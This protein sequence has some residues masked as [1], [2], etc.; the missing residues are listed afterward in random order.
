[1][2]NKE[3]HIHVGQKL[4]FQPGY[5]PSALQQAQ[6]AGVNPTVNSLSQLYAPITREN[7]E[8]KLI[9]KPHVGEGD[10]VRLDIEEQTEEI[11][12]TDKVRGPT[13]STRG[14]KTTV[15]R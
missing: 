4:P 2:D 7:V 9:V 12:A 15:V 8:L 5:T 13:T 10:E 14:T 3:W 1:M 11:V 6:N